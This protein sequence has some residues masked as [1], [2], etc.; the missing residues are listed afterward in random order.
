MIPQGLKLPFA[1]LDAGNGN[2][3]GLP[4]TVCGY[5]N[6]II[7]DNNNLYVVGTTKAQH[8]F[9]VTIG[10]YIINGIADAC[11]FSPRPAMAP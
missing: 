9:D 2:G 10:T 8:F 5:G 3:A 6:D 7:C 4:S 1:S 11:I